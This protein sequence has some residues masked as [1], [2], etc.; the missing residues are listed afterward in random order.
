M[1]GAALGTRWCS[2]ARSNFVTGAVNCELWTCGSFSEIGGRLAR[3][4]RFG[5]LM[6]SLEALLRQN[7]HSTCHR[8]RGRA[9]SKCRRLQ[10]QHLVNLDARISWPA[11]HFVKEPV[12]L[13]DAFCFFSG[14]LC[15]VLFLLLLLL[16]FLCFSCLITFC[17]CFCFCVLLLLLLLLLQLQ[18]DKLEALQVL[19]QVARFV[20]CAACS[21][22]PAPVQCDLL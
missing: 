16:L 8:F 20:Y 9:A 12:F 1:P 5:I 10:A 4:L 19:L 6:L 22:E 18:I 14:I 3:K 11:Q 2:S 21:K 13:W 7:R 15:F 17:F